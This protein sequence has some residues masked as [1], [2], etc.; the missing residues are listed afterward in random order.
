MIKFRE[1]AASSIGSKYAERGWDCQDS[2]DSISF[3]DVQAIAVADGHGGGDYFRSQ[4]GSKLAI[5]V[6]FRQ[7]R[8]AFENMKDTERFSD[9]GIKNFKYNF[10][11]EWRK[12]VRKDWYDRLIDGK[13]LGQDEIRYKSVSE[14]YK[15]RYTSD[16][17]DVVEKYLY[18]A[19]GTTLI[20]AVSIGK[21]ILTLQIG[22]GSCVLLQSNGEFSL[23]IPPE[24]ENFLNMTVSLCDDNSE[25]K[26]RHAVID[27]N[28]PN[29]P[30]AI[31]LS[32]DGLDDC[33]PYYQNEEHLY[34][35]YADVI[36]DSMVRN[37][38]LATEK[39]IREQ[40]L[41]GLTKKASKDDI[42]LAYLILPTVLE[43]RKVFGK[44]DARYKSTP[45]PPKKISSD[46]NISSTAQKKVVKAFVP[47]KLSST[48]S[49]TTTTKIAES[50]IKLPPFMD[51]APPIPQQ[52]PQPPKQTLFK[53][54]TV[55]YGA[56]VPVGGTPQTETFTPSIFKPAN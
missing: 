15:A 5:E 36:I 35:F 30:A 25:L 53:A 20:C 24:E 45:E 4:I 11:N 10:V 38:F 55:S 34:K 14:K 39:E 27:C 18:V 29:S 19:Y 9:T 52:P 21:Q 46:E 47:Q 41:P 7:L 12:A 17:P 44:I 33:F 26:I 32:T 2:S 3:D 56:P 31:F 49:T 13:P 28:S 51:I 8:Y 1:F 43:L 16:N 6:L 54:N 23:P 42:S 50:E 40:L 22:D 37:F 48:S